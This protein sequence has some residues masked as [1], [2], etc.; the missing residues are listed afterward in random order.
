MLFRAGAVRLGR[1]FRVHDVQVYH[2]NII[3]KTRYF[4]ARRNNRVVNLAKNYPPRG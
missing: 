1:V 4:I 2:L 3:Y